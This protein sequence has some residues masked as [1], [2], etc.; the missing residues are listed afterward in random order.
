MAIARSTL[1][2]A[3]GEHKLRSPAVALSKERVMSGKVDKIKGH[4]KEA[5]GKAVGNR[6]LEREGKRDQA[7]GE[8]KDKFSKIK[9]AVEDK[10]DEKLDEMEDRDDRG[11]DR[12]NG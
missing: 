8:A 7:V 10:V 3:R 6:K 2:K 9:R 12:A 11:R 4:A 1:E 5:V